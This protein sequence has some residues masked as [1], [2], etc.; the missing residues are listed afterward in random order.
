LTV[1]F[2]FNKNSNF[3]SDVKYVSP[4]LEKFEEPGK[5]LFAS[6]PFWKCES[7]KKTNWPSP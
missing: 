3:V 4:E 5:N 6:I 7:P 2:L 1:P